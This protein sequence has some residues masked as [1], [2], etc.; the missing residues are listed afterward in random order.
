MDADPEPERER[1]EDR[2]EGL[3]DPDSDDEV[4]MLAPRESDEAELLE[5][6]EVVVEMELATL[7]AMAVLDNDDED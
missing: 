5:K 6:S 1:V 7:P 4:P 3:T 2:R